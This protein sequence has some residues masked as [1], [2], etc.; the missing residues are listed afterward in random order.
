MSC[1]LRFLYGHGG[2]MVLICVVS[3]MYLTSLLVL[4]DNP[5]GKG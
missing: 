3:V 4:I 5:G 2:L 1:T